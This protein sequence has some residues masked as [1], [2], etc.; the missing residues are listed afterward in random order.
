MESG[1]SKLARKK[2]QPINLYVP[3]FA[4]AIFLGGLA[5]AILIHHPGDAEA[6]QGQINDR[7]RICMLQDTI[8][9]RSGLTYVYRGKK[10]YLC[11]GGC[12]AAFQQ[13]AATHSHATDPLDGRSVDKAVAPAYA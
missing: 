2:K 9:P 10:Y 12:L 3:I 13:D 1:E 5:V 11:C 4:V 6:G 8:Q 7:S